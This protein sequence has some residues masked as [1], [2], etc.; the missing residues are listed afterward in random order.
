MGTVFSFVVR[1]PSPAVDEAL[2][3]A[4]A[5][6][7]AIDAR[8]SPYRADSEVGRIAHGEACVDDASPELAEVLERCAEVEQ[9]TDGWFSAYPEGRLDPSGWVKGWAV[10]QACAL[11]CEAG[12]TE[13]CV[14]G[15]GDVQSVGGPWRVGV[16]DPFRPGSLAAVLAGRDLVVATSGTA[17]RGAHIL[18]P[19]T[20]E[21]AAG[22]LS[23]TL[24]SSGP[25][26]LARTD[27]FA[28]AAFAMGPEQGLAWVERQ[29]SLE[30]LAILP[31]PAA[32]KRATSEFLRFSV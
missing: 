24:V 22:L 6:L 5:R 28:T 9:L 19:R 30:A 16:A 21:S 14:N 12:S 2:H 15:G 27:A 1:D 7:H 32:P 11:L 8:F 10:E 26:R 25:A 29:P 4:V 23:L 3:A 18:D 20:G 31:D 17:E 13:H